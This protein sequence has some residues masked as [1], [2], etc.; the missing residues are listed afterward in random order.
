VNVKVQGY[1]SEVVCRALLGSGGSNS[2]SEAFKSSSISH[3]GLAWRG[4]VADVRFEADGAEESCRRLAGR[5][6]RLSGG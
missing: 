5:L 4:G 3:T 6:D 2:S 1:L